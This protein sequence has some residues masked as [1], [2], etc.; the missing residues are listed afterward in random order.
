MLR[1][2]CHAGGMVRGRY[3]NGQWVPARGA[4]CANGLIAMLVL[5]GLGVVVGQ[6]QTGL[7]QQPLILRAAVWTALALCA[8][9]LLTL[10]IAH[11]VRKHREQRQFL[12]HQ[13]GTPAPGPYPWPPVR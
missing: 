4:G 10:W 12:A 9:T 8:G 11:L 6:V 1:A 13:S 5:C 7:A 2:M 3:V